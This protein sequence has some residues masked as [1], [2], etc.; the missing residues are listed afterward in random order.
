MTNQTTST[1]QIVEEFFGD[2]APLVEQIGSA[3][4]LA[5]L[6]AAVSSQPF[7]RVMDLASLRRFLFDYRSQILL[8]LELPAICRAHAHAS[9]CEI[10]ELIELDRRLAREPLLENFATAS[11]RVGKTQLKK[12][13]PLRDQRLVQ[14][15]LR[16]VQAG[17][18]HGWH[19]LVYGV[20]L[21]LYSLPL[22]QGLLAYARQT[23][24]G[25]IGGAAGHLKLSQAQ[26]DDLE[27]QVGSNF[28]DVVNSTLAGICQTRLSQG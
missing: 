11:Q 16:A 20:I 18:A 26:C 13:R 28:A 5:A 1:H 4:G 22:R 27:D 12:L 10:R 2:A 3:E 25:F 15:Y 9:R 14:R 24:R 7:R 8:P 19:T 17:D 21:S 6:G 23:T